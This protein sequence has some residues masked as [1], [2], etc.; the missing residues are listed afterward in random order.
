MCKRGFKDMKNSNAAK[1][2]TVTLYNVIFPLW[3]LV[4]IP[5]ILWLIII[6]LNYIV[7]RVVFT[8]SAK[9]QNPEL[10][11]KFYR[12][13]TWKLWLIGFFA[14]FVGAFLLLIPLFITPPESVRRNYNASAFGKFMN[15]LQLN[16]FQYLPTF[17]YF[18]FAIFVA[19]ALIYFLDL[20]VIKSTKAFT[21]T[22]AKRIALNMAVF[23]APYLYLLPIRFF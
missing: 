2:N 14:D 12:R 7:D 13:H 1:K 18:L 17:L 4:W 16:P 23:T 21:K 22:Q 15:A 10:D 11:K 19:G 9:K 20:L 3:L 8:L 6:P 5:S